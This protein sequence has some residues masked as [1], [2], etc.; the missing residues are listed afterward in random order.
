MFRP[1]FWPTS[2]SWF[3]KTQRDDDS[4]IYHS[5]DF[6]VSGRIISDSSIHLEGKRR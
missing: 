4:Q 6:A 5:G 3:N 2:G 1:T